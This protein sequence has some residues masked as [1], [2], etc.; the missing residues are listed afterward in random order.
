MH[1]TLVS[2]NLIDPTA[3]PH[4]TPSLHSPNRRQVSI[5][6]SSECSSTI[7]PRGVP[8]PLSKRQVNPLKSRTNHDGVASWTYNC[9]QGANRV[10]GNSKCW[11]GGGVN[12]RKQAKTEL[13]V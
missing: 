13:D 3:S 11:A 6:S 7:I 2:H 4:A 12:S 8:G 9:R 1:C 5:V 10:H